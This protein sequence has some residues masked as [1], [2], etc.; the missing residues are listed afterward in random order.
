LTKDLE[1][2]SSP[3]REEKTANEIS[4]PHPSVFTFCPSCKPDERKKDKMNKKIYSISI[5]LVVI[6]TMLL[7]ACGAAPT[8][9]AAPVPATVAPTT[10]P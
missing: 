1:L 5:A 6:T 7:T 2:T 8:P 9:T 3:G 10:P 4:N